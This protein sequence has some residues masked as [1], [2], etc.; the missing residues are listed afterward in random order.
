MI[1]TYVVTGAQVHDSQILEDLLTETDKGQNIYAD[2]A[3]IGERIDKM[4]KTKEI[5]PQII[6]RAFKN[7]PLTDRQKDDNRTKSKTR[8]RGEHIFGFITQNMNDFYFHN[9]GYDRIKGV[10]GLVNLTYNMFRYEQIVRLQILPIR[11]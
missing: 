11:N 1:D 3:Y 2:S 6:E 4:L 5:I 8:S 10:V 9:I 7:N